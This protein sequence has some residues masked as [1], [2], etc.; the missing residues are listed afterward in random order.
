[1]LEHSGGDHD[2]GSALCS[3]GLGRAWLSSVLLLMTCVDVGFGLVGERWWLPLQARGHWFEP[4]C[5]HVYGSLPAAMSRWRASFRWSEAAAGS[6]E[7]CTAGSVAGL[8]PAAIWYEGQLQQ[9]VTSRLYVIIF[10]AGRRQGVWPRRAAVVVGQQ[11]IFFPMGSG[12]P[13]TWL[14]PG[15]ERFAVIA[16]IVMRMFGATP[17]GAKQRFGGDDAGG[18]RC[19]RA[20]PGLAVGW[21]TRHSGGGLP[22]GPAGHPSRLPLYLDSC[23]CWGNCGGAAA[24]VGPDSTGRCPRAGSAGQDDPDAVQ[25]AESAFEKS[26]GASGRDAHLSRSSAQ[27]GRL[28]VDVDEEHAHAENR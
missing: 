17:R 4:S 23:G 1:L 14:G 11:L 25:I 28:G 22:S 2:C 7:W 21:R 18:V 24:P 12:Q 19:R 10:G 26:S 16:E 15:P 27:P 3:P 8:W 13:E 9:S 5:A 6:G 20:A